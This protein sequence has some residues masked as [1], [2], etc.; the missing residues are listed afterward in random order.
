MSKSSQIFVLN[1]PELNIRCLSEQITVL[2]ITDDSFAKRAYHGRHLINK[3]QSHKTDQYFISQYIVRG[4]ATFDGFPL[5]IAS[6]EFHFS[7][8]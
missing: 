2:D 6:I 3:V 5:N 7:A 1:I 8:K 4:T